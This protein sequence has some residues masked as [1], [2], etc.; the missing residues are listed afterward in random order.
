M[1]PDRLAALNGTE[2]DDGYSYTIW[3]YN[4]LTPT[5]RNT[6]DST[7]GVDTAVTNE[8]TIKTVL[9]DQTFANYNGIVAR[10]INGREARLRD[11]LWHN[12]QYR[13]KH[14]EAL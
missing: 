2:Y 11:G 8:V 12:V 14:L 9:V 10:P 7:F 4:V 1:Y 13:I 6:L 3:V 5:E